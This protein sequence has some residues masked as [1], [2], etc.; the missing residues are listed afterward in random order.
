MFHTW[1][2]GAD[3]VN[4]AAYIAIRATGEKAW[5][6]WPERAR[7]R[8]GGH[9]LV[10]RQGPRRG[11]GGDRPPQQGGDGATSSTCRPASTTAIRPGAATS[12]GVVKGPLPFFWG[13]TKACSKPEQRTHAR[14]HRPAHRGDDPGHGDRRPVRVQPA[15]HRAGRPGRR[16]RRRPGLAGGCR[17]ASAKASAST[18]RSWSASA[19]GPGASCNVDLGTS[20]FT[21]LPVTELIAQRHRADAVADGRDA[22]P[23]GHHRRADGR[24][25]RLEGRAPGSTAR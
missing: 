7:G 12:S 5:F 3:C 8:E 9:R 23:R 21:G 2:A 11:E 20:I 1:H 10:R 4:P 22:D 18:G 16:D 6:G 17:E 14:L 19:N 24:R 13:V 15:L 25:R